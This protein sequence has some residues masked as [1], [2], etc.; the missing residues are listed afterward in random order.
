MSSSK[1]TLSEVKSA[2]SP[3]V[4]T[5]RVSE[6]EAEAEAE[7]MRHVRD[8]VE[9]GHSQ[10]VAVLQTWP[11]RPESTSIGRYR[12]FLREGTEGLIERRL[13][14]SRLV[15][16]DSVLDRIR[17]MLA[18]KPTMNSEDITVALNQ[19]GVKVAAST[20]RQ[21]LAKEGLSQPRGRPPD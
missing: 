9:A 15:V 4:W 17:G 19:M 21:H 14:P 1:R 10:R 6:A 11:D 2:L 18:V 20:V 8:L 13:K 16:T 12:K 7:Q 5:R 3:E